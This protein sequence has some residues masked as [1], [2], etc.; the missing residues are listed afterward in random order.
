[1]DAAIYEK[2]R[3]LLKKDQSESQANRDTCFQEAVGG[4]V[5]VFMGNRHSTYKEWIVD[6]CR[7]WLL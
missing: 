5:K 4:A 1:M 7:D 2:R 6:A 3:N